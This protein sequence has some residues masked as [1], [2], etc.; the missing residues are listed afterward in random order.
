MVVWVEAAA[1]LRTIN[2]SKW[3]KTLPV[4]DVPNTEWPRVERTSF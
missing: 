1:E 3:K 2:S 4:L